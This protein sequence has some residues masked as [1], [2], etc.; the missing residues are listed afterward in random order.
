MRTSIIVKE[1]LTVPGITTSEIM[2]P[3]SV[4]VVIRIDGV[5]AN[6]KRDKFQR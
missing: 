5:E 6:S 2:P 3:W 1:Y 4:S